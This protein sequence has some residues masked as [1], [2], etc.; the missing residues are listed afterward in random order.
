V[1]EEEKAEYWNRKWKLREQHLREKMT[2]DGSDGEREFDCEL[3]NRAHGRKVLDVGCGPGEFTLRVGRIAKTVTGIDTSKVALEFAKRNLARSR[4]ENVAFRYGDAGKLPFRDSSFD[5]AYSRRGPA[6]DSKQ[7]LTEIFRV[8]RRGGVF[9]EITIG[10][11]DKQN[12]ARIFRRG[13]KLG[14][15]GQVSDVKK[16]WLEQVGFKIS[17]ARDYLA[18][19]I[20]HSMNDLI[21][22]LKTAPIIPNFDV[23]R[24]EKFLEAVKTK[25]ITERGIE[26]QVHRVVLIAEK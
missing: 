18:T 11:R 20:F 24:D 25:C 12:V 23:E 17:E 3:I 8:L 14:F 2:L 10:E 22:R 21:I 4:L 9:M 26:T 7:N 13:Q 16:R 5:L 19:E 15:K 6:S 1:R